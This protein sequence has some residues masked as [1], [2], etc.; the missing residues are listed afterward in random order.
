MSNKRSNRRKGV[1][2][3]LPLEVIMKA[4]GVDPD[5]LTNSLD[6]HINR[7]GSVDI[8][9]FNHPHPVGSV[10]GF[11]REEGYMYLTI[12][13]PSYGLMARILD[14]FSVY[15]QAMI[16]LPDGV[17]IKDIKEERYRLTEANVKIS[18]F[19]WMSSRQRWESAA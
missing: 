18:H 10:W 8:V 11:D 1:D 7:Y 14:T 12:M 17:T 5:I 19:R 9:G 4:P 15:L 2:F 16:L 13:S 6:D 3:V